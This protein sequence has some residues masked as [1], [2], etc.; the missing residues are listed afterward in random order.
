[1]TATALHHLNICC[2]PENLEA[3]RAFYER[4]L[5]L[6]PGPRPPFREFGYWLYHDG[7]PWVHIST[8]P[9]IV[10]DDGRTGFGHIAFHGKGYASLKKRLAE[11]G[12]SYEERPSPDNRLMQVFFH[13]PNGVMLELVYP[14]SVA[15]RAARKAGEKVPARV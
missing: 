10:Q 1:M 13:D 15:R 9:K 3:T 12:I 8:R 7:H 5:G 6:E 14:I 4:Y 11:D 2:T